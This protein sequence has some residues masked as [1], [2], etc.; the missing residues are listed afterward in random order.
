MAALLRIDFWP[1]LTINMIVKHTPALSHRTLGVAR[2][3]VADKYKFKWRCDLSVAARGPDHHT[4][5]SVNVSSAAA[6][7]ARL[8]TF[9][10]KDRTDHHW[11]PPT[12]LLSQDSLG[13]GETDSQN[14]QILIVGC[15][16]G[17]CK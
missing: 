12:S 9:H 17:K 4:A 5:V 16:V 7:T 15:G 2:Q 13:S 3:E 6:D 1:G 10:N 14:S 11:L 8:A